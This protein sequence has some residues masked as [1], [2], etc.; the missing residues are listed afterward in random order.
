MQ[1]QEE[2]EAFRIEPSQE[3]ARRT[4]LILVGLTLVFG[5]A[6]TVFG[7]PDLP[8]AVRIAVPVAVAL[9]VYGL[10]RWSVRA[11]G[12]RAVEVTPT[13]LRVERTGGRVDAALWE[14]MVAATE[15]PAG[16]TFTPR[17]RRPIMVNTDGMETED[18]R[19]MLGLVAR[20]R[21]FAGE[22]P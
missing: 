5:L 11:G 18:R 2:L 15:F 4:T 17:G 1:G 7:Y 6:L 9:C 21:W 16:V 12:A 10:S 19:R 20:V 22:D 14:E 3:R 8:W 13:E